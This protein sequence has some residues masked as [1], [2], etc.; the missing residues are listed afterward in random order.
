MGNIGLNVF[1]ISSDVS[2]A[3]FILSYLRIGTA[4]IY[5]CESMSSFSEQIRRKD[6]E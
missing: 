2:V 1:E 3:G 4:N 5:H 6:K